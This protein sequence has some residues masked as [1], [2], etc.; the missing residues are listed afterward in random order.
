MLVF[1]ERGKPL[2]TLEKPPP[3]HMMP[4]LEIEPRPHQWEVSVLT[5]TLY[6]HLFYNITIISNTCNQIM[7]SKNKGI[8]YNA[9]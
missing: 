2:S 4:G 3:P 8:A 7:T 9:L 1:E 6:L 5:T